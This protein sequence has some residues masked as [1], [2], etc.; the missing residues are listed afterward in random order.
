[1]CTNLQTCVAKTNADSPLGSVRNGEPLELQAGIWRRSPPH[2]EQADSH[3]GWRRASQHKCNCIEKL[4]LEADPGWSAPPR[5]CA[6]TF[7]A[8]FDCGTCMTSCLL[9]R[10]RNRLLE[11]M[12]RVHLLIVAGESIYHRGWVGRNEVVSDDAVT[13]SVRSAPRH[14]GR[15]LGA[16]FGAC[17]MT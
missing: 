17:K 7:G 16:C 10:L 12:T 8:L 9:Q 5:H 2:D 13:L 3:I 1:M 14:H 11:T 6:G 4:K 15:D